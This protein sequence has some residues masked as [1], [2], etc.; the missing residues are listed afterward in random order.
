[1]QDKWLAISIKLSSISVLAQLINMSFY[2]LCY[3]SS[4]P[5]TSEIE[6]KTF[7][8]EAISSGILQENPRTPLYVK[9]GPNG[10]D[11]LNNPYLD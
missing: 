11:V 1:M 7:M 5:G 4:S 3:A 8:V 2:K 6:L 9:L 10:D